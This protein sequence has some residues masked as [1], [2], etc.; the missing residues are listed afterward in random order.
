MMPRKNLQKMYRRCLTYHPAQET[1]L[2]VLNADL[3]PIRAHTVNLEEKPM[4]Q[5][6]TSLVLWGF[7]HLT[8]YEQDT[9][10]SAFSFF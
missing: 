1:S 9:K 4:L 6:R 8:C 7:G 10:F 3:H 5:R 2:Q